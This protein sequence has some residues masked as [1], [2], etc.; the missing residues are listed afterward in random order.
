MVSKLRFDRDLSEAFSH[1]TPA[2]NI[3]SIEGILILSAQP[4]LCYS[5]HTPHI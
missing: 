1:L 3:E 2:S 4:L 5:I